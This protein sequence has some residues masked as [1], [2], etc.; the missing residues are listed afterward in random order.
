MQLCVSVRATV[1]GSA[2][3]RNSACGSVHECE[4]HD[5]PLEHNP[6]VN[7]RRYDAWKAV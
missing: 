2:V 3:V 5:N 1:C 6:E 7:R 4:P